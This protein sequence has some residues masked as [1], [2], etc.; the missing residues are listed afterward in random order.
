MVQAVGG[1]V[2]VLWIYLCHTLGTLIPIGHQLNAIA[3]FSIVAVRMHPFIATLH[4]SSS[5]YFQQ[6]N[7]L[8]DIAHVSSNWFHKHDNEISVLQWPPQ[9]PDLNAIEQLGDVVELEVCNMNV[10]LMVISAWTT[11]P[12][13]Y[14]HPL[15]KFISQRF[16]LWGAKM[17]LINCPV[18]VC[19]NSPKV[20]HGKNSFILCY[21]NVKS[22]IL[23]MHEKC[24]NRGDMINA[25]RC[26]ALMNATDASHAK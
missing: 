8:S 10:Q 12:E 19:S 17:Y 13:E 4:P 1:V 16:R 20:L 3:Y 24:F 23:F 6:D 7:K 2:M 5:C 25:A 15:I 21:S 9:S 14:F 18:S 26:D 22:C 11:T